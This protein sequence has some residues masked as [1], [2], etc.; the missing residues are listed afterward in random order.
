M[1]T[2]ITLIF[3]IAINLFGGIFLMASSGK[4][5]THRLYLG[6][7]F[8]NSVFMYTGHF[9]A[10]FEYWNIFRWEDWLFIFTL[11][12][13]YPFYFWFL[14]YAF[15]FDMIRKHLVAHFIPAVGLS[16]CT[17]VFSILANKEEFTSYMSAN[18]YG[19]Q[20]VGFFANA[21][22][23][24][25]LSAR[26]IHIIQIVLYNYFALRFIWRMKQKM[27]HETSQ[28]ETQAMR[29]FYWINAAFL[30]FMAIPGVYVTLIGR[31]PFVEKLYLLPTMVSIF[32]ILYIILGIVGFILE[33]V[34]LNLIRKPKSEG[35]ENEGSLLRLENIENYFNNDQ[36]W[37]N[38][39]LSIWD[40]AKAVGV[41]RTYVSNIINQEKGCNFNTFVNQFRIQHAKMILN[42]SPNLK[43]EEV[44]IKSGFGSSS[45]FSRAF[46]TQEGISPSAYKH[47]DQKK[48]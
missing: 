39:D 33:P 48:H 15:G 2:I 43:L 9:L 14:S 35:S 34:N 29:Y 23:Y 12:A 17:L 16:F 25:Y 6:V 42:A 20:P 31:T 21:L 41:N 44:A 30:V 11:M 36:P 37:L 38:P 4:P 32:L 19:T 5:N 27:Q 8:L 22:F 45:S 1:A 40:V 13:F 18:V 7:F 26:F 46:K 47:R 3:A 10:F 24:T 28:P